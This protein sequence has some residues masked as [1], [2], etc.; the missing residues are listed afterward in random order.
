MA[1]TEPGNATSMRKMKC[2]PLRGET[3]VECNLLEET[4]PRRGG[5]F[6]VKAIQI[7]TVTNLFFAAP[8]IRPIVLVWM[9]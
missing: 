5:I 8:D 9:C 2:K 4:K 7:K 6:F 3:F 1:P